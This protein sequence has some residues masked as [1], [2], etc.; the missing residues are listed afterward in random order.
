MRISTHQ[1]DKNGKEVFAGDKVLVRNKF[2]DTIKI[3]KEN[4]EFTIDRLLENDLDPFRWSELEVVGGK[5]K[6]R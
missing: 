4:G 2:I 3:N 6:G 1:K 5:R